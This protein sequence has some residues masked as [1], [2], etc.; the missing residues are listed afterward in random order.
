MQ[1]PAKAR[2]HNPDDPKPR[3]PARLASEVDVRR[4]RFY[5]LEIDLEV[6]GSG[7]RYRDGTAVMCRVLEKK[8]VDA[9]VARRLIESTLL[10]AQEFH[11]EQQRRDANRA[12]YE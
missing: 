7:E 10:A 2:P 9:P 1:A 3:A 11:L 4:L 5:G 8:K 12:D 6:P